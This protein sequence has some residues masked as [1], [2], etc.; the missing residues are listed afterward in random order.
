MNFSVYNFGCKVNQY[1]SQVMTE[2]MIKSGYTYTDDKEKAD[3]III[4]SCT[5]TAVADNKV[6]KLIRHIKRENPEKI[7]VLTGCMPQAYPDKTSELMQADIVLGNS[8]RQELP[9]EVE[10]YL[11]NGERR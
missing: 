7:V 5:V 6:L 4:N 11:S 9:G 1:E 8:A 2:L 10:K 3:I